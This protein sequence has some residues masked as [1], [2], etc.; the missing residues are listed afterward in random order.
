ME[1]VESTFGAGG[2]GG[3]PAGV[4][5]ANEVNMAASGAV[6]SVVLGLKSE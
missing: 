3:P 1:R 2:G 6:F 5:E 4:W